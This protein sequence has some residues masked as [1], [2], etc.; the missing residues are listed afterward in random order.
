MYQKKYNQKYNICTI[1][2]ELQD[3]WLS[4]LEEMAED[5]MNDFPSM[6]RDQIEVFVHGREYGR[7]FRIGLLF[8]PE[9]TVPNCY[10]RI[11][12]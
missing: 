8:A 5:A 10:E 7:D 1:I 4:N 2:G 12:Y 9:G 3:K 6:D 11:N